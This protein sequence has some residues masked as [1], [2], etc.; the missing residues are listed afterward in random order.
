LAERTNWFTKHPKAIGIS[1]WVLA[2]LLT[3]ATFLYQD[4]TGPTQPIERSF[5]TAK[6]VVHTKFLRSE[7]IGTDLT[8]MLLDPIPS[9]VTAQVKYR[10]YASDDSFKTV[11]MTPMTTTVS[12]RGSTQDVGGIGVKL[13][14]LPE[15]AG[16]YEYFVYISDGSGAPVSITGDAPIYAR[17]KGAV[18]TPVLLV[19]ILV[20]FVSM[21][22]ALRTVMESMRKD[23][24]YVWMIWATLGSLLLG[25]F[26]MGPLVQ[27]YAFNVWWSGIPFGFDWTD[28]KVLAELVAWVFALVM[29]TGGRRA[30]WSVWLAGIVTLAVY[31]IPHSVFGS[32]YNYRSG[33]GRGTTG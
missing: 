8:V 13:P 7:N 6:G 4:Q 10:R 22:F 14:S 3:L 32:E 19:H 16:K 24:D 31:F 1:L 15:R 21:M 18:P 20:I 28:N 12:R 2:A 30:R 25:A 9:G 23:G 27:W 17:Y 26:V 5:Q 29:N 33:T 11:S